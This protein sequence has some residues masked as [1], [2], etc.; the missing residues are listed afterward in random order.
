MFN[1]VII[2]TDGTSVEITIPNNGAM[3]RL[4]GT[5]PSC[6]T[7]EDDSVEL[8]LGAP[9]LLASGEAI[10]IVG[11]QCV[12]W[13]GVD[14]YEPT[15][16]T[17]SLVWNACD[18]QYYVSCE[19]E[20]AD[21]YNEVTVEVELGGPDDTPLDMEAS[22]PTSEIPE[23]GEV[24]VGDAVPAPDGGGAAADG[25]DEEPAD[26]EQADSTSII[27]AAG[28]TVLV[29]ALCVARMQAVSNRRLRRVEADRGA[30]RQDESRARRRSSALLAGKARAASLRP[31]AA[32]DEFDRDLEQPPPDALEAEAEAAAP[33]ASQRR[34]GISRRHK[35]KKAGGSG[36]ARTTMAMAGASEAEKERM[37]A[38]RRE[39]RRAQ[40]E[41][42]HASSH[43]HR[44]HGHGHGHRRPKSVIV[45]GRRTALADG[46]SQAAS[47]ATLARTFTK[48]DV[49]GGGGSAR[50]S[51][52]LAAQESARRASSGRGSRIGRRSVPNGG[53]L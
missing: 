12:A 49:R 46:H 17:T 32:A 52:L 3:R 2:G 43:K 50:R 35:G 44:R 24:C 40:S 36:H 39:K 14:A 33:R 34:K 11:L 21:L 20:D 38:R 15:G 27:V 51:G 18:E 5:P 26:G 47:A 19:S 45:R 37:R 8:E 9:C 30:T 23:A 10:V 16:V 22:F 31:P 42:R 6:P 53:G 41:R 28:A 4:D 29:L 7:N 25:D 13:N 1:S 48:Y